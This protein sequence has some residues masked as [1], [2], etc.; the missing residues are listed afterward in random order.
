MGSC[1]Y[2]LKM[3]YVNKFGQFTRIL[4]ALNTFNADVVNTTVVSYF[5]YTEAVF[6]VEVC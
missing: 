5:G 1:K 2:Q 3:V 6:C 4:E